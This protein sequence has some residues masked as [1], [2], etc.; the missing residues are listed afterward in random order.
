VRVAAGPKVTGE[1]GVLTLW[2]GVDDLG[3]ESPSAASSE[4]E[5]MPGLGRNGRTERMAV[6]CIIQARSGSDDIEPL[7]DQAADV[8]AD[9]EDVLAADPSLGI[10]GCKDAGVTGAEWRHYPASPG[11]AVRVMFTIS[12]SAIIGTP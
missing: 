6:H 7:F 3:N 5:W 8:L 2:V 11:M 1:A 9:V 4:Q 12:A 10:A